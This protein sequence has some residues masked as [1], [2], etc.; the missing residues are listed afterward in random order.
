MYL[1]LVFSLVPC[2]RKYCILFYEYCVLVIFSLVFLVYLF[3][4]NR[5][6]SFKRVIFIKRS[7]NNQFLFSLG[8]VHMFIRKSFMF[9][10]SRVEK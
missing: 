1:S 4:L 9:V 2:S 5:K 3:R 6:W 7:R 10:K 8:L